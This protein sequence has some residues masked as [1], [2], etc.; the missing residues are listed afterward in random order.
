[1]GNELEAGKRISVPFLV[2]PGKREPGLVKSMGKD[3]PSALF[4]PDHIIKGEFGICGN[5][6][7]NV[8]VIA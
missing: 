7:Q 6:I 8:P 2:V 3:M 5:F 4:L 1:M